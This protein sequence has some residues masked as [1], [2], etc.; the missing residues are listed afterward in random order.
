MDRNNFAFTNYSTD[1]PSEI[2]YAF[3][4]LLRAA[5]STHRNPCNINTI[6]TVHRLRTLSLWSLGSNILHFPHCAFSN[7]QY[8][9]PLCLLTKVRNDSFSKTIFYYIAYDIITYY[10]FRPITVIIRYRRITSTKSPPFCITT[11]SAILTS[12]TA[13]LP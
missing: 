13:L 12:L 7:L 2:Q 8:W 11:F 6:S 3:I 9:H 4:I 1:F 5:C 10:M